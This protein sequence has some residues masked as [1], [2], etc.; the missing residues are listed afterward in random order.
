MNPLQKIVPF[1]RKE[2]QSTSEGTGAPL[3]PGE[4][5]AEN[6]PNAKAGPNAQLQSINGVRS[7]PRPALRW[8]GPAGRIALRE[9]DFAADADIVCGFQNDTYS[10]NFPDFHY[11]ESFAAAFR[12]DL[13]RAALDAHHA[14]F[15]LDEGTV[16]GFLWLV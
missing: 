8:V 6:S 3:L 1:L 11:T 12:H 2:P 10:R 4:S 15:V 16:I 7:L 14:L 9:F 13:R 5:T